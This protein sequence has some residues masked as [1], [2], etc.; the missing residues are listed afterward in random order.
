[1]TEKTKQPEVL[2]PRY[3]RA[4]PEMEGRALLLHDPKAGDGEADTEPPAATHEQDVRS[5]I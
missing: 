2:N 1:M 4:T 5:T 3:A